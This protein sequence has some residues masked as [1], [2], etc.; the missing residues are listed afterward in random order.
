MAK[1][2]ENLATLGLRGKVGNLVFRRRGNK[3]TVYALPKREAAFSEKQ[4]QAQQNF[5]EAVA[6]A[7][8]SLSNEPERRRFEELAKKKRKESAYSAA[9]SYYFKQ[10]HRNE[11]F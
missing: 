2:D 1:V 11:A 10:I 8:Q 6:R 7:K 4:K 9:I 3:T 5:A